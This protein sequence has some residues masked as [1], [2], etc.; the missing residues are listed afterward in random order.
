V[1]RLH[2]GDECRGHGTACRARRAG[3]G[4]V[5]RGGQ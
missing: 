2:G 4:R 1:H 5:V 3:M